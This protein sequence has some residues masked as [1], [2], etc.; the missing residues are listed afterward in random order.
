VRV[1]VIGAGQVGSTVVEALHGDHEL[2]VLDLVPELL[3]PLAYRYDVSTVAGDAASRR[4]L[5]EAGVEQANLLIACTTRDEVNV[6]AAL[7]AR[8][9]SP[10]TK[11]IVR[12]ANVEYLEIWREGQLDADFIVSSEL[13]TATAVTAIVG[14]PAARQTDTFADGQVQIVEFDVDAGARVVGARLRE[15]EV[16]PESKVAGIIRAG[17]IRVPGGDDTI[18]AGDRI[19]VIGSPQAAREWSSL[20]TRGKQRVEDV[21]LFGCGAAGFAVARALLAQGIGVR[22]VEAVERRAAEVAEQ[23]PK[24]RV[25]RATGLEP[26][27]LRRERIGSASAAVFAMRDDAKNHYAAALAKLHGVEFTI[28]IVHETTAIEVFEQAGIDVAI[29]PRS[30]TAEEIVR[31]ARD[32]RTAQVAMLEQ[33]RFE[34][35][36]ITVR[37]ESRFVNVPFRELPATRSLIGAL[38][39]DG[40]ALFPHGDDVLLPGDRAIVFTESARVGEVE[41]GL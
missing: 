17:E 31:F 19:I 30:L 1:L 25:Y 16:P 38:V 4:T 37:P 26:E 21:V 23:L 41:R 2:T 35:L 7:F 20:M 3:A 8:K 40:R 29:D 9:L 15:A 5:Q 10:E 13:E 28:A 39:R 27:F 12:T 22:I 24:A 33:D 32:P 6:I 18:E 14:V 11:T 34:V 36:D